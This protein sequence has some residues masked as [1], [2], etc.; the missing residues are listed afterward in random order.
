[1]AVIDP[2]TA[3]GASRESTVI[4]PLSPALPI[5]LY[6]LARADEA[7]VHQL[8]GLLE[9]FAER[10]NEQLRRIERADATR[11]ED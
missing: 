4:R 5:T 3:L 8:E 7:P 1:L 11:R 2:F 10:A 6:A 9:L